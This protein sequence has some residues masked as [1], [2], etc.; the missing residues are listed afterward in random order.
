MAFLE[1][2]SSG[3]NFVV[4]RRGTAYVSLGVF[5][6]WE[7]LRQSKENEGDL[8]VRMGNTA[9]GVLSQEEDTCPIA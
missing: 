7:I 6:L 2:E 3:K 8:D 5:I 9:Q 1:P 4:H